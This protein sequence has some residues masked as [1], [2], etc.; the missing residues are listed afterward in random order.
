[1]ILANHFVEDIV[2]ENPTN[3]LDCWVQE[4]RVL[5]DLNIA[6]HHNEVPLFYFPIMEDPQVSEVRTTV[7]TIPTSQISLPLS[8]AM[9]S[10]SMTKQMPTQA[11]KTKI[12]KTKSKKTPSGFSQK[13]PVTKSTEH[14][15]GSVKVSELG[16]GQGE[17]QRSPKDKVGHAK[18]VRDTSSSQTYANKKKSEPIGNTQGAH[19]VPTA[20]KD[21]VHEPSQI[22]ID[23]APINVESQQKS[24]IIEAPQ[25]P[26]SPTNSLDVDMINTSIP[27]SPS[28][29]LL[30]KPNYSASSVSV[31]GYTSRRCHSILD[32]IV[33]VPQET[34][35]LKILTDV[36]SYEVWK[37]HL[38]EK[39][40]NLL[41]QFLPKETKAQDE[42]HG[43]FAGL[44][45]PQVELVGKACAS[46]GRNGL[47]ALYDTLFSQL[48]VTSSQSLVTDNDFKNADFRV[49]IGQTVNALAALR[50]IPIFNE[51][52][53]ISTRKAP[54]EVDKGIY[55]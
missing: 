33:N 42:V 23:V 9:T 51:N 40:R 25:T 52:D 5:A 4:S 16:E 18:R 7:S 8:V 28:L 43:N 24:L 12:S 6:S 55:V 38:S 45:N 50:S 10:V 32:D 21:S 53:A 11:T 13:K 29:T 19:T 2:I 54:Y 49:Q 1:M 44:Q 39:E 34:F 14:Q 46:V 36:P 47:M 35:D 27:D 26:N 31:V 20:V 41:T 17:H 37:T 30:G 15:E 22:Q 48:D 3:K